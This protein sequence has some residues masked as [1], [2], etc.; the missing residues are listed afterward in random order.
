MASKLPENNG[1]PAPRLLTLKHAAQRVD[2]T[3]PSLRWLI[4]TG[5]IRPVKVFG[6]V[7]ITPEEVD[8]AFRLDEQVRGS[9]ANP[10]EAPR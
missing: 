10:G 3:V 4:R 9:T 1:Q 6:R 7:M 2:K 8:R 5:R